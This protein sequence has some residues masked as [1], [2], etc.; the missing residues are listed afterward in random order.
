MKKD[1]VSTFSLI[2]SL[3]LVLIII[4]FYIQFN[5]T[6]QNF[7]N[8]IDSLETDLIV[9]TSRQHNDNLALEK[10]LSNLYESQGQ[11]WSSD[12]VAH[13]NDSEVIRFEY[14]EPTGRVETDSMPDSRIFNGYYT[15]AYNIWYGLDEHE[16]TDP[17]QKAYDDCLANAGTY[18]TYSGHVFCKQIFR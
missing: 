7:E 5:T 9:L 13:I 11:N 14:P 6:N 10:S 16:L 3:G 2:S 4:L 8:Q 15:K 12:F 17:L 18:E 1:T